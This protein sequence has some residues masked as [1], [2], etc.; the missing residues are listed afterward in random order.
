MSTRIN[1]AY[2]C[3]N[4]VEHRFSTWGTRTPGGTPK[5]QGG[6]QNVNCTDIF[7]FGG[8]RIPKG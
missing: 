3:T 8:T 7:R 4:H 5:A 6:T 1:K 2:H